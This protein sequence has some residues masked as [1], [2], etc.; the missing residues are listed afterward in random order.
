MDDALGLPQGAF[1]KIDGEADEVF[2][3]EPRLVYQVDA[4]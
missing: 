4:K 2:Y 1:T 3:D